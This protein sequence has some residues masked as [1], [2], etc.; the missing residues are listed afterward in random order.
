M[1]Q[2]HKVLYTVRFLREV[3]E[4][5]DEAI[6]KL[7][8]N[9]VQWISN[10]YTPE[11]LPGRFKPSWEVQFFKSA[12]HEAFIEEAKKKNLYHYHIGYRFYQDSNDTAYPGKVSDGIIH[13]K[14]MEVNDTVSHCVLQLCTTHPS[15]FKVPFDRVDDEIANTI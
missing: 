1:I 12:L 7:H 10:G 14:Q 15:P 6:K 8:S 4:L 5:D 9:F 11:E 2:Q 13:T 3:N